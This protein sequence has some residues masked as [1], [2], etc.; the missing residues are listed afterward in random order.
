MTMLIKIMLSVA[1][2]NRW[3][4]WGALAVSIL[5]RTAVAEVDSKGTERHST[6]LLVPHKYSKDPES[7]S[8]NT[9]PL[10]LL[11]LPSPLPHWLIASLT[12]GREDKTEAC[13]C[14]KSQE[15]IRNQALC[16]VVVQWWWQV[17]ML[18]DEM[19]KCCPTPQPSFSH[20]TA[21]EWEFLLSSKFGARDRNPFRD[22]L[23]F[24]LLSQYRSV[25]WGRNSNEF[26]LLNVSFAF[27]WNKHF[28]ANDKWYSSLPGVLG[29]NWQ[30]FRK[31]DSQA[32]INCNAVY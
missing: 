2:N 13:R 5:V 23:C 8:P 1:E 25:F 20:H 26:V 14:P 30:W 22:Q 6:G 29:R 19:K 7:S 31:I 12:Q 16:R 9:P 4:N 32:Q 10:R 28:L 15:R 18:R 11:P 21:R 24:V 17:L 27:N 3:C